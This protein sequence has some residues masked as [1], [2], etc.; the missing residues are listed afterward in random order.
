MSH[1]GRRGE[2]WLIV[3]VNVKNR[4]ELCPAQRAQ[5]CLVSGSSQEGNKLCIFRT[6]N[7][8]VNH[9]IY[10]VCFYPKINVQLRFRNT[11]VRTTEQSCSCPQ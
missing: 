6:G 3:R 8:T 11:D 1:K 10:L 7:V 9:N 5:C 2:E 4:W